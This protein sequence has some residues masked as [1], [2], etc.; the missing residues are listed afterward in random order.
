MAPASQSIG[1]V[2]LTLPTIRVARNAKSW[3]PVGITTASDAAEKNPRLT[4]GRPVVN[5]WWTQSPKLRNPVPTA[6]STIQE[7]P[8]IGVRATVGITIAAMAIEGSMTM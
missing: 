8:T 6:D 1:V 2:G 5:M 4:A 3:M 7:Y